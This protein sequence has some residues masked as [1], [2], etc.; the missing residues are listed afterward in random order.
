METG[1]KIEVNLICSNKIFHIMCLTS[2]FFFFVTENKV[3]A[4]QQSSGLPVVKIETQNAAP[5][6]SKEIWTNMSTFVL[7]DPKNSDNNVSRFDINSLDSIRGR[8]NSTWGAPK[9]SYRIKF[10]ENVSLFGLPA[11]KNWVLLANAF[12]PTFINN[13]FACELGNRLKVPFT[14]SYHHVE[15]YLNGVYRGSYVLTEHRQAAPKGVE[16]GPGRVEIDPVN[17]WLVEID[18]HYTSEDPQFRT[19]NYNLPV[20]IKAPDFPL[21]NYSNSTNNH[22]VKD[23]NQFC[24]VMISDKFPE[25]GYREMINMQSIIDY[26][27]V[28]IITHNT[29]FYIGLDGRPEPGSIF[30]HKGK[31]GKITAGP[32]WDFDLSFRYGIGSPTA[33]SRAYPTY[34]FFARFLQDPI[35]RVKWKESWN[36]NSSAI[37]SMVL[38]IDDL[39]SIIRA[40]AEEDYK[41]WRPS[42]PISEFDR[43]IRMMKEYLITRLEYLNSV[44]NSVDIFPESKNFGTVVYNDGSE[45]PTQKFSLIAYGETNVMASFRNNNIFEISSGLTQI[46]MENGGYFATI[47]VRP[48]NDLSS[49]TYNDVLILNGTNQGKNFSLDIPLTCRIIRNT[50]ETPEMMQAKPLLAW[51]HNGQVRISGIISGETLSIYNAAGQLIYRSIATSEEMDIPLSVNGMYIVKAGDRTVRFVFNL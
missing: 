39:A 27:L 26:F 16:P 49:G 31:N 23:W 30:I 35:F 37:Y 28:Q 51:M 40:S 41:I 3:N 18:F 36:N 6:D 44:Y 48:K 4:D 8:G 29:D 21:G 2:F 12:D 20:L 25:N 50:T 42:Q 47:N 11:A 43:R 9:K 34:P 5:I 38:F 22:V 45:I 1:L 14:P 32:L 33:D 13:S 24:D 15:L 46:P 10:R 19:K 17:G 7:T